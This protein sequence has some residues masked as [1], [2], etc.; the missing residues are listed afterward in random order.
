MLR[1]VGAVGA[2]NPRRQ[3]RSRRSEAQMRLHRA[4]AVADSAALLA[5]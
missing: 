5:P 2:S 3:A 4:E 1:N